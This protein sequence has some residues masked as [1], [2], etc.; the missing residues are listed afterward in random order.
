ME[1]DSSIFDRRWEELFM[2][3]NRT[4]ARYIDCTLSIR[5]DGLETPPPT[6]CSAAL[7]IIAFDQCA[8]SS[9]SRDLT[10]LD[11]GTSIIN[12]PAA[13]LGKSV[14]RFVSVPA[15][16]IFARCPGW[17]STGFIPVTFQ[18]RRIAAR[19]SL[20]RVPSG[21]QRIHA[22]IRRIFFFYLRFSIG[23]WY[24]GALWI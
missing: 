11:H 1:E 2:N 7:S 9:I 20:F 8:E 14:D 5:H 21:I 19:P 15:S 17:T 24:A 10:R 3:L 6:L 18:F 12:H 16:R 13:E 23:M 4:V 22:G